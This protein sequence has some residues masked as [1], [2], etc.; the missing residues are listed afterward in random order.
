MPRTHKTTVDAVELLISQVGNKN[1][2][3]TTVNK[4]DR[5]ALHYAAHRDE[6]FEVLELLIKHAENKNQY[7]DAADSSHWTAL[8]HAVFWG[9]FGSV[10]TLI[11]LS[12]NR[13]PTCLNKQCSRGR[14]P[15]HYAAEEGAS[16]IVLFLLDKGADARLRHEEGKTAWDIIMRNYPPTNWDIVASFILHEGR[17]RWQVRFGK[18]TNMYWAYKELI[19]IAQELREEAAS[20]RDIDTTEIMGNILR[21]IVREFHESQ[22][23]HPQ[24]R[25]RE[26]SC[27]VQPLE[28]SPST[29]RKPCDF[30]SLVIPIIYIDEWSVMDKRGDMHKNPEFSYCVG[31]DH[32]FLKG[33]MPLTLDEY[34]RPALP[35]AVLEVRNRDQVLGRYERSRQETSRPAQSHSR[36]APTLLSELW[37]LAKA[38][39]TNLKHLFG[40]QPAGAATEPVPA[41]ELPPPPDRAVFVGQISIW[42]IDKTV[43][44]NGPLWFPMSGARHSSSSGAFRMV[45]VVL[46]VAVERLQSPAARQSMATEPLFKTYNNALSTIS[47][48]VNEYVKEARVEDIDIGK[49]KELFHEISDL[50]EELS[51]IKSV[52]AEQEQ[53]CNEFLRLTSTNQGSALRLVGQPRTRSRKNGTSKKSRG[54]QPR[55]PKMQRRARDAAEVEDVVRIQSMFNRYRQQIAKLEEDAE[56]VE[57]DVSIQLDLKQKHAT[58]KEAHS[59]AILSA[60]VFGFTIIT[61]IFAPLSFIVA[62]F[63]LPID[64]FNEGKDGNTQDGVYSS[65]YI[66]KWSAATELVSISVTVLAMWAALRFAGLHIWGNKGLREYIRQNAQDARVAEEKALKTDVER[67]WS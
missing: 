20:D 10:K 14:T 47:E 44:T 1:E 35:E 13:L 48:K 4:F 27:I 49:E 67:Q 55:I 50:R 31:G 25:S 33:N 9:S 65:K 57:R 8:H 36:S 5:T 7:I 38:Y 45:T 51:M 40:Q 2:Y 46:R 54:Y 29:D 61:V 23:A 30:V 15:L 19:P 34:C 58:M 59:V 17:N 12:E 63:A 53:V 16:K 56:R 41:A 18:S 11:A 60:T 52:L 43:I 6:E 24:L 42:I 21:Q 64:L 62:L 32:K 39:V 26:P 22:E 28:Y 3:V 66:G 37:T